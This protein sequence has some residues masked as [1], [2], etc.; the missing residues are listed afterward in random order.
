MEKNQ[1]IKNDDVREY[2]KWIVMLEEDFDNFFDLKKDID[3]D[4]YKIIDK[5]FENI[6]HI[7]E[8][9][10]AIRFG[11]LFVGIDKMIANYKNLCL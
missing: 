6:E 1:K 10:K 11:N 7:N 4:E 2:Y 3:G 8:G 5:I 9:R